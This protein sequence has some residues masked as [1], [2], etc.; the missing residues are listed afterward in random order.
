MEVDSKTAS[1][2]GQN[3]VLGASAD[4]A[5]RANRNLVHSISCIGEHWIQARCKQSPSSARTAAND[6][7]AVDKRERL[8]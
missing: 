4:D 3:F 1:W 6:M 5:V 7:M 8:V 2:K